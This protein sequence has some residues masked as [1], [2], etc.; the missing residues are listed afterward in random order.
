MISNRINS[1]LNSYLVVFYPHF[2]ESRIHKKK[3]GI[4]FS[5]SDKKFPTMRTQEYFLF[6]IFN[7]RKYLSCSVFLYTFLLFIADER[8]FSRELFT[9]VM[10]AV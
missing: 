9:L 1:S 5:Y 7:A 10:L 2:L 3:L 6:H 4:F 8:F